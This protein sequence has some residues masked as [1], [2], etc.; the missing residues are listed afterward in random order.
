[1]ENPEQQIRPVHQDATFP[2]T[3][4]SQM[5][6]GVHVGKDWNQ[7]TVDTD[8]ISAETY[9]DHPWI[10]ADLYDRITLLQ[11]RLLRSVWTPVESSVLSQAVLDIF[12]STFDTFSHESFAESV[13]PYSLCWSN[14]LGKDFWHIMV[15]QQK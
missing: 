2:I 12:I 5:S 8:S 6:N 13:A 11:G 1:M 7:S 14:M 10:S 3:I 4:A 9:S 15:I